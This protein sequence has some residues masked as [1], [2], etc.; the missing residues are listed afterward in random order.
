[1]SN[2]L[3]ESDPMFIHDA[4]TDDDNTSDQ[5]MEIIE[6]QA[7]EETMLEFEESVPENTKKA[8]NP[9]IKEFK[10]WCNRTYTSIPIEERFTVTGPKLHEFLKTMVRVYTYFKKKPNL[11]YFYIEGC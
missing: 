11:F 9:K 10:E 8:Y 2:F 6:M 4:Y 7:M 5:D 1:M 3:P